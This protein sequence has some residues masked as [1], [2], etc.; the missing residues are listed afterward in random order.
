MAGGVSPRAAKQRGWSPEGAIEMSY[1][2]LLYHVAFSTKERRP[3]ITDSVRKPLFAYMGGVL[4][5]MGGK[6]LI[7]NGTVDHVHLLM[8]LPAKVSA[9]E[10]MRVVKANSSKWVHQ[11][12]PN[13]RFFAWQDG[14]AA[15]TVSHSQMS[16]VHKYIQ[17]QEAHHRKRTF[18]D[19]LVALLRRHEVAFDE[20]FLSE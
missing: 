3:L 5:E 10:A 13:Q 8:S 12:W 6:A 9:A 20:R 7:V 14:F 1:A 11:K 19:E 15:F 2:S 4:R 17:N 18:R 16:A